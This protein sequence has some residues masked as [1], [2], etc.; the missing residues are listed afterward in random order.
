MLWA[1]VQP[2]WEEWAR[3]WGPA[4]PM[5]G[6]L[7]FYIHQHVFRVVPDGFKA[8]RRG[9]RFE[10]RR[11]ENRHQEV[12]TLLNTIDKRLDRMPG[13]RSKPE[14]KKAR[15]RSSKRRRSA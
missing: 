13:G 1:Q 2:N 7:V 8:L 11:A 10:G 6:V 15:P 14:R 3:T 12:M 4:V 5:F 9:L